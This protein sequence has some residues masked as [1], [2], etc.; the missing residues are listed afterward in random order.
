MT[1]YR[2]KQTRLFRYDFYLA[3]VRYTKRG[4]ATHRAAS[5]AEH[6]L[7]R[8]LRD[9]RINPYK[10]FK[11]L[12][13]DYLT[14]GERTHTASHVNQCKNMFRKRFAHL[15]NLKPKEITR[16]HVEAVLNKMF[17]EGYA[18]VYINQH[19]ALASAALKYGVSVGALGRNVVTEI[20]RMPEDE[21]K[22][23]P[24]P[25]AHLKQL[26]LGSSG[27]LRALLL[28][29][30]QTGCRWRE[31]SRLEWTDVFTDSDPPFCLLT[32]RKRRSGAAKKRPQPLTGM[33][34]EG[35][36]MQR[37]RHQRWVFPAPRRGQSIYYTWKYRLEKLCERLKLPSYGFHQIRHWTGM[38]ATSMGKSRKAVAD[39]LGH[40]TTAVTERYMHALQPEMWEVARRIEAELA[41]TSGGTPGVDRVG[42]KGNQGV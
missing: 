29:I 15:D 9:G 13:A 7:R 21:A 19:R 8:E 24:I 35:I 4:F 16:G 31:T 2:D 25:T 28:F 6:E 23:E 42:T 1:A 22:V 41:D 39:F 10:T 32:S 3:G 37:G 33:A 40:T 36:E 30:S 17:R 26:L 12:V 11:E 18:A 38:T 20:P 14:V 27:E 5:D 34:I